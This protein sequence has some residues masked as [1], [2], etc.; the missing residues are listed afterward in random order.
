MDGSNT[1]DKH[2]ARKIL[3]DLGMDHSMEEAEKLFKIIDTDGGGELDFEEFVGFIVML[4][5]GDSRLS[6]FSSVLE[7]LRNTPLGALE[8]QCKARGL[9]MRFITLEERP[10]TS[11]QAGAFIVE[12]QISG[13]F[14]SLEDGVLVDEFEVRKYQGIG[15]TNRAAKG[16]A[17]GSALMKLQTFLP[18]IKYTPGDLP[19]EWT[20]WAN[21]NLLR[22]VDVTTILNI[23]VSKG[24]KPHHNVA[25]MQRIGA[26]LALTRFIQE[27]PDFEESDVS[28]D[29]RFQSWVK[30]VLDRGI[31]GCILLQVLEDRGLMLATEHP[32]YA[33]KIKNNEMGV[34]ID[35]NGQAPKILDFWQACRDGDADLV[36][37]YCECLQDVNTEQVGRNDSIARTPLMLAAMGNHT[38]VVS[39]L[40]NPKYKCR[41]RDVDRRGRTALHLAA[42]KGATQSCELLLGA[43]AR[44]YDAEHNGDTSLHVAAYMNNADTVDYLACKAQELTRAI[45]S[46][47]VLCKKGSNF[48]KLV[49]EVFEDLPKIKLT[50][51]ET[52]RFE[53]KWLAEASILFIKYMDPDV[54]QYLAPGN[55]DIQ[56]DVLARFDP[57]P[58]TGIKMYNSF[59]A[60]WTFVPTIANAE[61][62][63][64]LLGYVFRQSAID[65][66]NSWSRTALHLACEGNKVQSHENT[67]VML[68]DVHGASTVMKDRYGST[69]LHLLWMDRRFDSSVSA[70]QNREEVIFNQRT[71][72]LQILNSELQKVEDEMTDLRRN[73]VLIDARDITENMKEFLWNV[74]RESSI[75]RTEKQKYEEYVD[76]DTQSFFYCKIPLNPIRGDLHT[77]WTWFKPP[78]PAVPIFDRYQ[79]L[80]YLLT[81]SSRWL[82]TLN[83]WKMHQ[84][85]RTGVIFYYHPSKD[86]ITFKPPR[87]C[88]LT[89]LYKIHRPDSEKKLGFGN[90]W[91]Q[92]FIP[93]DDQE[94]KRKELTQEGG[95]LEH[96][97]TTNSEGLLG[98]VF[99]RNN[100]TLH[101][102]MTW[103]RP[104]DAVQIPTKLKFCSAIQARNQPSLQ[105][106]YTCEECN[107][108]WAGVLEGK[109]VPKVILCEPCIFRCHVG[110]KGVR[111]VKEGRVSCVCNDVCRATNISCRAREVSP[112]Q[113]MIQQ[114]GFEERIEWKRQA[115]RDEKNPHVFC[116]VPCCWED[117]K[118]PK[119]W[120][121]WSIC[122]RPPY[123]G[124]DTIGAP[125]GDVSTVSVVSAQ[126]SVTAAD[127]DEDADDRSEFTTQSERSRKRA[128]RKAARELKEAQEESEVQLDFFPFLPPPGLPEGWIEV[129]DY[130]EDADLYLGCRV[131][132]TKHRTGSSCK[133]AQTPIREYGTILKKANP[134]VHCVQFDDSER[135]NVGRQHIEAITKKTFYVNI[136]KGLCAW[137][138]EEAGELDFHYVHHGTTQKCPLTLDVPDWIMLKDRSLVRRSFKHYDEYEDELSGLI[139]FVDELV[140]MDDR[141]ARLIQRYVRA[142]KFFPCMLPVTT[143][144]ERLQNG[145]RESCILTFANNITFAGWQ[146][147]GFSSYMPDEVIEESRILNAWTYIQRRSHFIGEFNSASGE[148]WEEYVDSVSS[149]YL[150]WHEDS[151]THQWLKPELSKVESEIDKV[152]YKEDDNVMFRFPGDWQDTLGIITRIRV[153]DETNE[154]MYDVCRT[155]KYFDKM[156]R[157]EKQDP[158][159]WIARH[160]IKK[161]I[162]DQ[163]QAFF[164]KLDIQLTSN[165]RRTKAAE[166]RKKK[167]EKQDR[168][169]EQLAKIRDKLLAQQS[170]EQKDGQALIAAAEANTIVKKDGKENE[171][172]LQVIKEEEVG[173]QKEVITDKENAAKNMSAAQLLQKA[174]ANRAK[175]E[176][177][178]VVS[179]KEKQDQERRKVAVQTI[180]DQQRKESGD[181][182][183]QMTRSELLALQRTI[184]MKMKI[185]DRIAERNKIQEELLER[186]KS[187]QAKID[188]TEEILRSQEYQTTTP[189]SLVR[190]RLLRRMHVAMDRQ[191]NNYVICEWGCGDW[192]KKGQ[193]QKEHQA[194]RCPKRIVSCAFDCGCRLAQEQWFMPVGG[195]VD[196]ADTQRLREFQAQTGRT[197]EVAKIVKG[198]ST[199][200]NRLTRPIGK[201]YGSEMTAE[202]E[203][204]T[205]EGMTV[206]QFHEQLGCRR[207]LT[208]CPLNCLEWV[209]TCAQSLFLLFILYF[210]ILIYHL[211]PALCII[212]Y[213]GGI[214]TPLRRNLCKAPC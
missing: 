103:D 181:D 178:D 95:Q 86:V 49:E 36:K 50:S 25:M 139:F 138:V 135:R 92:M 206:Q 142:W 179:E 40:L 43:G 31:D 203:A 163:E 123:L 140:S 78:A 125:E 164:Q 9:K 30:N 15:E 159:Q 99:Y 168:M 114:F 61:T 48:Q 51:V 21:D 121:G 137:T 26:W 208:P 47:K 141:K 156:I 120:G 83:G 108:N 64:I 198:R 213:M 189:R 173:A 106:Y 113:L 214:T 63:G 185:E 175:Q 195:I 59:T 148:E 98:Y 22:G 76:P 42:M 101:E 17:A 211:T 29:I 91:V 55:E 132:A 100:S 146:C 199:Y 80:Q 153:D 102:F 73:K 188:E 194:N 110:H 81:V 18:G 84:C 87:N 119:R 97:L 24:F 183:Q 1:I 104:V 3:F 74:V 180:V 66:G 191:S 46:D 160:R 202:D 134:L 65:T 176:A 152:I 145:G 204:Q 79:G 111:K 52:L 149:E 201:E 177:L 112:E 94:Q 4:K 154:P 167:K 45:T 39:I 96:C 5:K 150:Y 85:M 72:K 38:E 11:Q 53:K 23:L 143:K 90:E 127:S 62:L 171:N 197:N 182:G 89:S 34:M 184:D 124:Y 196:D 71:E 6:A 122:R 207:R 151:N 68:I 16:T 128:E 118:T 60:E 77:E 187:R 212:G 192:V 12:L 117:G 88:D 166:E 67:I 27:N 13:H 130:E 193:D 32:H 33:Q 131:L 136:E 14:V 205:F 75:L 162:L 44:I 57:R 161:P 41:V 10:A 35:F 58:E 54:S 190:R 169:N 70:T 129:A 126:D 28:V 157:D 115:D 133:L 37:M 155:K 172:Q 8:D 19:E 82:R 109:R 158:E 174:R 69:P 165:L 93:A 105:M 186:Q 210:C 107:R 209:R 200:A 2:E 147:T 20:K 170:E 56:R 144:I 116:P 7:T